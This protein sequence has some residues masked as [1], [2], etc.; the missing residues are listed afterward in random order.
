MVP[1]GIRPA[2]DLLRE[3]NPEDAEEKSLG[4]FVSSRRRNGGG[5]GGGGGPKRK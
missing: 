1:N 2:Q 4:K 5:R 3:H